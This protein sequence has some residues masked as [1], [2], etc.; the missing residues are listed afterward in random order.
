MHGHMNVTEYVR[1]KTSLDA[2]YRTN[3]RGRNINLLVIVTH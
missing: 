2:R 1:P 3:L